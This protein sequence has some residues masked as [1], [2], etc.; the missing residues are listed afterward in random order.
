MENTQETIRKKGRPSGVPYLLSTGATLKKARIHYYEGYD[1]KWNYRHNRKY[2]ENNVYSVFTG[3]L[4]NIIIPNAIIARTGGL[5]I[6]RTDLYAAVRYAMRVG[7]IE[8]SVKTW[9]KFVHENGDPWLNTNMIYPFNFYVHGIT[10]KEDG[11]MECIPRERWFTLEQYLEHTR[12]LRFLPGI[13]LYHNP[14]KAFRKILS[15][16]ASDRSIAELPYSQLVERFGVSRSVASDF[17]SYIKE[18]RASG[19]PDREFTVLV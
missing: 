5:D 4:H 17:K 11:S 14:S 6:Q 13:Q 2:G 16:F 18:R 1:F 8:S 7:K 9:N 15:A 10:V 12:V 3:L 19:R